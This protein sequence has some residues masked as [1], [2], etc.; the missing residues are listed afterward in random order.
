MAVAPQVPRGTETSY[1]ACDS[2]SLV[3]ASQ[4]LYSGHSGHGA[5]SSLAG[6]FQTAAFGDSCFK[7]GELG[8][9]ARDFLR[10][11]V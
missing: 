11:L 9:F 6:S 8:Q 7:C 3:L 2:H 1:G 4:G 10:A 5:H